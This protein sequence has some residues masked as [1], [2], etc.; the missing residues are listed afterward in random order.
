MY[1]RSEEQKEDGE[2]KFTFP[3]GHFYRCIA[4]TSVK[5]WVQSNP[6]GEAR[7]HHESGTKLCALWAFLWSLERANHTTDHLFKEAAGES[8]DYC[9]CH[10][11]KS[12]AVQ[13]CSS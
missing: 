12:W 2:N 1:K 10:Q 11:Q 9:C 4:V 8:M 13:G 5:W 6:Q 7:S 3:S